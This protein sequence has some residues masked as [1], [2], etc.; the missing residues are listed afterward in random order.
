MFICLPKLHTLVAHNYNEKCIDFKV[1]PFHLIDD[2]R[3]G[4]TKWKKF[5]LL[6]W[7]NY[8]LQWRHKLQTVAEIAI[9]VIFSALLVLIRSLVTPELHPEPKLFPAYPINTIRQW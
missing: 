8:L 4:T 2:D 7:K 3:M 1:F 9:P 6:M 5:K